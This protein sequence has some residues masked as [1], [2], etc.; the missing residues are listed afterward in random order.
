VQALLV[1]GIGLFVHGY[2]VQHQFIAW[3]V[4]T[5]VVELVRAQAARALLQRGDAFDPRRMH[6]L[7]VALAALS[8]GAIGLGGVLFLPQLPVQPQALFGAV[9]FAI[10]AAGVAVSQSSRYI[11][12]AY[13]LSTLAPPALAFGALHPTQAWGIG[14]LTVL[15]CVVL[16]LVAADGERLLLR[17]ILIRH[18]RDRLVRDLEEQ[19]ATVEAAKA[20]AE[21]SARARARVLAAASHDLRQPLHALSVFSAVLAANPTPDVLQEVGHDVD[22]IVRS[23]GNLLNGLLVLSRLSAGN[24]VPERELF[25]VDRVLR[26]VCGEFQDAVARK[27]LSLV[28]ELAPMRVL[29]DAVA[30][31][32]ITRNLIDNAIKYTEVGEVRVSLREER[33]QSGAP[34]ATI[35]VADTGKGIPESEHGKIFEP[36]CRV[37]TRDSAAPVRADRRRYRSRIEARFRHA[38]PDS[39]KSV[40]RKRYAGVFAA[41]RGR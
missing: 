5:V 18:E 2:V 19:N 34:V 10:P 36:R 32:R 39:P 38:D 14:A 1:V 7:F 24:Y 25:A 41:C 9:L 22:Q 20:Q 6:H 26:E 35:S 23:L 17:S 30:I 3:G 31:G 21:Q 15:Y 27:G 8:G 4:G 11:L 12:A 37:G 40:A 16:I 33:D 13:A 28:V 29:G